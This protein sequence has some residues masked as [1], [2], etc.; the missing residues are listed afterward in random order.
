MIEILKKEILQLREMAGLDEITQAEL[1]CLEGW[2]EELQRE[3]K[4]EIYK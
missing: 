2:L 3:E 1:E 4:Y